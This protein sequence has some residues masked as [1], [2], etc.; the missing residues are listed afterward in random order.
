M[1][2][3]NL[4]S[5]S[6][7][8]KICSNG[9]P[10]CLCPS[11]L[12]L[13]RCASSCFA[14][15]HPLLLLEVRSNTHFCVSSKRRGGRRHVDPVPGVGVRVLIFIKNC[16]A[17]ESHPLAMGHP[18]LS[19]QFPPSPVTPRPKRTTPLDLQGCTTFRRVVHIYVSSHTEQNATTHHSTTTRHIT[20]TMHATTST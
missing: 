4:F 13:S 11:C 16:C 12:S 18:H 7:K 1:L 15:G 20:I 8:I 19:Y 5:L 10:S 14:V 9:P 17:L 2:E 6:E 3:S